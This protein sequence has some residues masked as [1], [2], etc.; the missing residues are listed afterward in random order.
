MNV[1]CLKSISTRCASPHQKPVS[2]IAPLMENAKYCFADSDDERTRADF[3]PPATPGSMDDTDGM[4][5]SLGR[6]RGNS[7]DD[8]SMTDQTRGVARISLE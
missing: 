5:S 8:V 1:S 4:A 6:S 7:R 2:W 3:R